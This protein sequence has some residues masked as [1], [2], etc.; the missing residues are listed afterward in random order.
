MRTCTK[1]KLTKSDG[2]FYRDKNRKCGFC[3]HCKACKKEHTKTDGH[4]AV[5]RKS[6]LKYKYGLTPGQHKA[7]YVTQN[8]CC[9]VCGKPIPYDKI[10]VDHDHKTGKIRGLLCKSCN[11][12]LGWYERRKQVIDVYLGDA[13]VVPI[14]GDEG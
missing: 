9:V 4:K 10:Q 6:S 12:K 3:S 8:G 2:Q 1:C 14:I 5:Q 13:H 7:M 11:T